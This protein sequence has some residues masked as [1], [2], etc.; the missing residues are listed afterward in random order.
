MR[1]TLLT[2][3]TAVGLLGPTTFA[4]GG[5][6]IQERE[7][8][9]PLEASVPSGES[10]ARIH[11]TTITATAPVAAVSSLSSTLIAS[12]TAIIASEYS[13]SHRTT[14]TPSTTDKHSSSRIQGHTRSELGA[15]HTAVYTNKTR[16]VKHS[17][18]SHKSPH[19]STR[20]HHTTTKPAPD[21][22]YATTGSDAAYESF[23]ISLMKDMGS[24]IAAIESKARASLVQEASQLGLTQ[25]I[26]DHRFRPV[27][28]SSTSSMFTFTS[29][30]NVSDS[31]SST[32][33][34]SPSQVWWTQSNTWTTCIYTFGGAN[35]CNGAA[36]VANSWSDLNPTETGVSTTEGSAPTGTVVANLAFT[37]SE[38]R[39]SSK[40]TASSKKRVSTK[41]PKTTKHEMTSESGHF[42]T[43]HGPVVHQSLRSS[44]DSESLSFMAPSVSNSSMRVQST[45]TSAPFSPQQAVEDQS[46][47]RMIP[48]ASSSTFTRE[49]G[50]YNSVLSSYLDPSRSAGSTTVMTTSTATETL[51]TTSTS[52]SII[53]VNPTSSD[54][55]SYAVTDYITVVSTDVS[56]E[57]E[58]FDFTKTVTVQARDALA[59]TTYTY[60]PVPQATIVSTDGRCVS[61]C[62][63]RTIG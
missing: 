59:K 57:I 61:N 16:T 33:S 52:T 50:S 1:F 43:A 9:V 41:K 2:A 15:M 17:K 28:K 13:N 44:I 25:R 38:F 39:T 37:D 5:N 11:S 53:S 3:A 56:T 21:R 29:A 48:Q 8:A 46:K 6:A 36:P 31:A 63:A 27:A 18:T 20:K 32:T 40:K 4:H 19:S 42:T 62:E 30:T 54:T 35:T 22:A 60:D 12:V 14:H 34:T 24:D 10:S 49:T 58:T 7:P 26:E 23:A 47:T 51:L 45:P 55:V